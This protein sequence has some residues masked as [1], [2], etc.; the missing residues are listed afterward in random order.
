[1]IQ[2]SN[3]CGLC[4]YSTSRTPK[5]SYP[6]SWHFPKIPRLRTNTE[7]RTN[8]TNSRR[9][10]K[11][12]VFLPPKDQGVFFWELTQTPFLGFKSEKTKNQNYHDDSLDLDQTFWKKKRCYLPHLVAPKKMCWKPTIVTSFLR[13][14]LETHQ[15][16]HPFL[17]FQEWGILGF[18]SGPFEEVWKNSTDLSFG[19]FSWYHMFQGD[20]LQPTNGIRAF[21]LRK[22]EIGP[23]IELAKVFVGQKWPR[24]FWNHW[25]HAWFAWFLLWIFGG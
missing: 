10:K 4:S 9:T 1:M 6:T 11:W 14:I 3:G 8:P 21:F 7:Y 17:G 22:G 2:P 5:G 25:F 16:S 18:F 15:K 19:P 24:E 20:F 12:Q 13:E 23:R